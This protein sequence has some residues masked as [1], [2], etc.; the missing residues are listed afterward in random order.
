VA[1]EA[2]AGADQ[3]VDVR[4]DG[5]GVDLVIAEATVERWAEVLGGLGG[6]FGDVAGDR[7][8]GQFAV[9]VDRAEVEL[10]APVGQSRRLGAELWQRDGDG[11]GGLADGAGE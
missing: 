4:L 11:L 8:G 6:V 1:A 10:C 5:E 7:L 3:L 9:D 2:P